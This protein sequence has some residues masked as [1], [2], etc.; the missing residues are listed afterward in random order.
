MQRV[1]QAADGDEAAFRGLVR[2]LYPSLRRWALAATGDADEADE[3]V[4]RTLIRVHR[5]LAGFSGQAKLSTWAYRI[6]T[7]AVIDV[8]RGRS[9]GPTL[10]RDLPAD[11][12]E[13][14]DDPV[15]SLHA[16]RVAGEVR[17]AMEGLPRRQ[18][19]VAV[20]VDHEGRR[21]AEVAEMLGLKPVTIRA[22]LFKARRA[23]RE[24]ILERHPELKEG[25]GR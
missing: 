24:R 3:V 21:P 2:E 9:A 18:R 25:Y 6:L 11:V 5:G 4:Q 7:R 22:S 13:D 12:G 23:I 16:E 19:E 14:P 17:A 8:E 15:R 1:R 10:V 20:L